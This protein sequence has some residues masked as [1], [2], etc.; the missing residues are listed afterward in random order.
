MKTVLQSLFVLLLMG[1]CSNALWAQDE[2]YNI[3][4]KIDN[5]EADTLILGYHRGTKL[6]VQDTLEENSGK[7][8]WI[9]KGKESLP[10][11]L[12]FIY[13]KSEGIYFDFLVPN[14]EDQQRMVL[15]TKMD[16]S[17]NL[18]KNLKIKGS[19]DNEVFLEY[20]KD[21]M[22][23]DKQMRDLQGQLGKAT[24]E[25]KKILQEQG[26]ALSKERR[27][28]QE[29]LI[30][31][32]PTTL[33]AKMIGAS[34]RPE[35]PE[36]LS[37]MDA[38]LYLRAHY[39]DNFDWADE[40]LIRTPILEDK[41]NFWVDKMTVQ[42]PDSIA[43]AVD[44]MLSR[45]Q[46]AGNK[47]LFQYFAAQYLNKYAKSKIICMDAVYVFIG[48]KYY[49]SG[50]ADWVD[51]VQL[52]KICANVQAIKPLRCGLQAP[53]IRLKK[54]DGSYITLHDVKAKF[55]VLYFWDPTCGNCSKTSAKLVPVYEEFK[56]KGFEVF[57]VCSKS[58]KD[59]DQCKKKIEEKGMSFM[60]TSEDP[61]PLA[62][63]KKTYDLKANPYLV[64]LD[65][66]KNI[67]LKRI[68]PN[69][70]KDILTRELGGD[71]EEGNAVEAEV[72]KKE[73]ANQER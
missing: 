63:A 10:G 31:K 26:M 36:G 35:P 45:Y 41:M 33:T 42:A 24:E 23:N 49:C 71:E 67:L 20:I 52:E 39:W 13:L 68:D 27:A 66:N 12:Y 48:E 25:E 9:F 44:Y 11:G 62:V 32:H 2:G 47:D 16:A 73:R 1:L 34:M 17:R 51:S 30:E 65:E 54:M 15:H 21:G 22:V 37:R 64:L 53:N 55:T 70:L 7:G 56:D 19:K 28:R 69:Q 61:Y 40:R 4:V 8:E 57:G 50:D 46:A 5:Y 59:L 38:Y 18:T 14:K 29:E 3:R 6:L 60:N 72:E 58:W 43:S